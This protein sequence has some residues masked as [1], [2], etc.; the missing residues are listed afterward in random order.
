M[1]VHQ[2]GRETMNLQEPMFTTEFAITS[3]VVRDTGT[4]ITAEGQAGQYGQVFTTWELESSGDRTG[5]T[6]QGS[7]WSGTRG[8]MAR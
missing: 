5:G 7:G 1:V 8:G 2:K 4:T 3:L 6:Y